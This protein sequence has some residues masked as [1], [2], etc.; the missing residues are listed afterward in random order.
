[1]LVIGMRASH[2]TDDVRLLIM[3]AVDCLSVAALAA[4]IWSSEATDW[5]SA[6]QRRRARGGL[7]PPSSNPSDSEH[8]VEDDDSLHCHSLSDSSMHSPGQRT[9]PSLPAAPD[10]GMQPVDA[11]S[12]DGN[13]AG[14]VDHAGAADAGEMQQH[15]GGARI[16][17]QTAIGLGAASLSLRQGCGSGSALEG[18]ALADRSA[19]TDID[20]AMS[21]GGESTL[22]PYASEESGVTPW[23]AWTGSSSGG[24][25]RE[26]VLLR[27]LRQLGYMV[28]RDPL[29]HRMQA[30]SAQG[31]IVSQ[32]LGMLAT[33]SATAALAAFLAVK[34]ATPVVELDCWTS[35]AALLQALHLNASAHYAQPWSGVE[36]P[37]AGAPRGAPAQEA[38]APGQHSDLPSHSAGGKAAQWTWTQAGGSGMGSVLPVLQCRSSCEARSNLQ[39]AVFG[40]DDLVSTAADAGHVLWG[41]N[42]VYGGMGADQVYA[43]K[44]ALCRSATHAKLLPAL[45]PARGGGASEAGAAEGGA[46]AAEG[47]ASW[48]RQ[49][50]GGW[51]PWPGSRGGCFGIELLEGR[52]TYVGGKRNGVESLSLSFP[53]GGRAAAGPDQVR[54]ARQ[55]GFSFRVTAARRPCPLDQAHYSLLCALPLCGA[56][57]AACLPPPLLWLAVLVVAYWLQVLLGALPLHFSGAQLLGKLLAVP[58]C[59]A[60]GGL[61]RL[62]HGPA[63]SPTRQL[64]HSHTLTWCLRNPCWPAAG[65]QLLAPHSGSLGWGW[66]GG[67]G[68]YM[69]SCL[70][71]TGVLAAVSP[72]AYLLGPAWVLR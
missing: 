44:S 30:A 47:G 65:Q 62:P 56:L 71:K 51:A 10:A 59:G 27:E 54:A 26:N 29:R 50:L 34:S 25:L 32:R 1:V 42:D 28:W 41:W 66:A 15:V 24:L 17:P 45:Q 4:T 13:H 38:P 48:A 67:H 8:G 55:A 40:T 52:A 22:A 53:P 68:G 36:A 35:G 58:V 14:L 64:A 7:P 61:P 18:S 39:P 16:Q 3:G 12:R 20:A 5:P 49:W 70:S 23:T 19:L 72:V 31:F 57:V 2:L 11:P 6:I 37:R 9:P 46:G 33:L 60:S 21:D 63:S 43:D 69:L